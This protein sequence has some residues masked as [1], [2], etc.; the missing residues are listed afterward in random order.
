MG[1]LSCRQGEVS[2]VVEWS[3]SPGVLDL[4]GRVLTDLW[5]VHL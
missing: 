4:L 1:E 5:S 2:R 3:R